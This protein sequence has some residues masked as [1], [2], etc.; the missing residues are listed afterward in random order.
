MVLQKDV[1]G[2]DTAGNS[3]MVKAFLIFCMVMIAIF[4]GLGLYNHYKN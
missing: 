1:K 3:G 2:V 4:G